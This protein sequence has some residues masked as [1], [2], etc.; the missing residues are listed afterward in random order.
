[1]VDGGIDSDKPGAAI[2]AQVLRDRIR[3]WQIDKSP[4]HAH[5]VSALSLM[6]DHPDMSLTKCRQALEALINEQHQKRV[7]NTG[8]KRLDQ[9]MTELK[10]QGALPRKISALCEVVRE[11]GNVGAHPIF[12]DEHLTHREAAVSLLALALIVEWYVRST[13]GNQS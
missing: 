3:S 10:R 9:L 12:D 5:L 1:M 6:Q 8:T 4:F 7:G 11:L 2:F 13:E